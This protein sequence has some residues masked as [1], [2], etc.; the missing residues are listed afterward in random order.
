MKR[1]VL[2]L[3]LTLVAAACSDDGTVDAGASNP[4]GPNVETAESDLGT[5]LVDPDGFTLYIFTPDTPGTSTCYEGC[6]DNWPVVEAGLAGG[7]GIDAEFGSTTRDDGVE[8]LT[9]NDRPVYL[10]IGDTEPGATEG[11]EV[12]GVWFV[13]GADGDPIGA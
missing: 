2:I 10:F 13:I 5:I 9:I 8:Q 6:V 12:G 1:T 3:A 11:Q 4:D 7:S